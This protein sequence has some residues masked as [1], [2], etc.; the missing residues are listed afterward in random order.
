MSVQVI[1]YLLVPDSS[2]ARRVRRALVENSARS[3]ILVGTWPELVE[4]A[5][6]AYL[7]PDAGD[8]WDEKL[9]TALEA[10]RGSFWAESFSVSPH[11]TAITVEKVF[12]QLVS[13]TDPHSELDLA[14]SGNLPR[15]PRKHVEDLALL[16]T[17]LE[18]QLPARLSMVR[19]LLAESAQYAIQHL[20]VYY[21][22]GLP[23]LTRWQTALIE[24]LNA[25][26]GVSLDA[27]LTSVLKDTL[28][29]EQLPGVPGGL[30]TLQKALF[31]PPGEKTSSDDSVQWVGVRDFLEEAEVAAGMVQHML[32]E[33][34]DL[35][36]SDIGLLLPERFE[37]SVAVQDAFTLAGLPLSG[38]P[39]EHWQRDLGREALFQFLYCRQKPAPAMALAV[40]L[41]S[42]LMP[43]SREEGAVLAQ[44]VMD[45]DYGLRPFSK[46]GRDACAM[47]DL[48]RKGDETPDSLIQAIQSFISLLDGGDE[49][50]GHV[51]QAKAAAE[52]A[53]TL[54]ET[55]SVID[56]AALRRAASPKI[57]TTGESPDF[58]LEGV[59]VWREGHEPWR[60]VRHLLIFGFAEG[61]YP[62]EPGSSPVFVDDDLNAI[63]DHLGLPVGTSADELQRRR[64]R[65]RRQLAAVSDSARFL[66]PHRDP[67]GADQA[68]S[69][70]LVFMYQLFDPPKAIDTPEDLV[71]QLDA[72]ADREHIHYLAQTKPGIPKPPRP[73]VASDI[74]FDRDLLA[75]RTNANGGQKPESPSSLETLMVSPLAWLLRRLHAEPLG[76]MPE[77]ANVMLLGTLAHEVFENLFNN[78]SLLIE[79][80]KIET[81]VSSLLDVAIRRHAPFLRAAQW[82]VERQHLSAGITK[83]ALAW[84]EILSALN[85]EVLGSEEWLAGNLDGVPIHGQADVLLGLP[86][87][88][89][90][91]V[92]YKRSSSRSRRP[93]MQRGYDSQASLY[94]TM[95]QTGGPKDREN[96]ELIRRLKGAVQTGI[97]Y[98]LLNDQTALSDSVLIESGG[99]PGWEALEGDVAGHAIE[100]IEGSL[101]KV[102]AGFLRL[103]R[104]GDAVFFEKQAGLKPYALENSPLIPLFTLPDE[105]GEAE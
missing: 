11:E 43:W 3:G 81:K 37:Y 99:I 67:H 44:T 101:Q 82:R 5:R 96:T 39:V 46:A 103:N 60:P 33:H 17:K 48:L 14:G 27:Q 34:E 25:D 94:R 97:V 65:F 41:S 1:Q 18:G 29:G 47:L 40:C 62:S 35:R 85:A 32:A 2:A 98:Y 55:V 95:L 51:Q 13:A 38:L 90:L 68:P 56:W 7:L 72:V 10:L 24:K 4:T 9:H 89:L 92:D 21:L 102:Q 73:I 19:R 105:A 64:A 78:E 88:R 52:S 83:A 23:H 70:S 36:H 8:D 71:L 59:T 63:R 22:E 50:A 76:W 12:Y 100:L 61:S 79:I 28:S 86:N 30:L 80:N 49:Y 6:N 74:E 15:R 84:R 16:Y 45:G 69:E 75:L 93:R 31:R 66:V 91:V 53:C 26:A 77:G 42:P 58:N 20:C 87:N 104:E 54:L 57:I